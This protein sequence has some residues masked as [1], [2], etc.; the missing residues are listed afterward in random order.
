MVKKRKQG[1][2]PKGQKERKGKRKQGWWS[3][4]KKI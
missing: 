4:G 2:G 1:K 3:K